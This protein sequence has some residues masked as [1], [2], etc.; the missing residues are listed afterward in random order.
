[1]LLIPKNRSLD[2]RRS[3]PSIA[4]RFSFA[5]LDVSSLACDGQCQRESIPTSS[6]VDILSVRSADTPT[7]Q[8]A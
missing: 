2:I 7:D 4:T 6:S 8:V 3:A 5:I 1:M